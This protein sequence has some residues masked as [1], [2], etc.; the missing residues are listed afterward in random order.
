MREN[1]KEFIAII[2]A[3]VTGVLTATAVVIIIIFAASGALWQSETVECYRWKE[4]ALRYKDIGFYL[5]R[6]QKAQCDVH[7]VEIDAEAR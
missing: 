3:L 1:T 5:T 6:W 4:Q 7:K 2:L